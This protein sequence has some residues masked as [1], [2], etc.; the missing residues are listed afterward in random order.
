MN[1]SLAQQP[2]K[3][4]VKENCVT[5]IQHNTHL[6]EVEKKHIKFQ[7]NNLALNF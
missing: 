3:D 7:I 2:T 4:A 1:T 5:F 6:K